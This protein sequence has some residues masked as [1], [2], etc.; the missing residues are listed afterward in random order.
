MIYILL[1]NKMF[2]PI[3]QS[4]SKYLFYISRFTIFRFQKISFGIQVFKNPFKFDQKNIQNISN[5]LITKI[6]FLEFDISLIHKDLII[7]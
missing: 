4:L 5:F 7:K 1:V 2:S 3:F 6:S